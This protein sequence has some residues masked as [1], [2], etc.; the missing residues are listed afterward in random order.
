LARADE[1]AYI[2]TRERAAF[3]E[4]VIRQMLKAGVRSVPSPKAYYKRLTRRG[5]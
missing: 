5:F 4:M 1:L 3:E 2:S